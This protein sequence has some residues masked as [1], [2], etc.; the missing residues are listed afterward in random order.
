MTPAYG[1]PPPQEA[2]RLFQEQT[3][4]APVLLPPVP[5]KHGG[6]G[7]RRSVQQT[8][9]TGLY[10]ITH[11]D[12]V[13][14]ILQRGILSHGQIEARGIAYVPIYDPVIVS[15]RKGI[16][17]ANGRSLWDYANAYFQA[18]NPMMY[19]V[20]QE[21]DPHSIAVVGIAPQVLTAGGTMISDGNAAH[22][23]SEILTT[24]GG[25]ERLAR[26]WKAI[27]A[28]W[29]NPFDGSKRV[30]MAECLVPEHISPSYIHTIYVPSHRAAEVLRAKIGSSLPV[31]PEPNMFFRPV[32]R[33]QIT[34]LLTLIEGDMFFSTMQTLTVSVNTVGIMGKGLASRAKDQFPD[35]YVRYQ[36]ACRR[37]TLTLG[38]PY[39][40]KRDFLMDQELADEPASLS[41]SNGKK[42]FLLFATKG[43]WR[44]D[45]SMEGIER[46]LHW[47]LE[48]H[49]EEGIESLAIPALG[50]GLGNLKWRDVGPLM[51]RLLAKLNIPVAIYLP[52][53]RIIPEVETRA[54]FLLGKAGTQ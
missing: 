24:A 22:S 34:P 10:Y 37:E 45:A 36:D 43:H 17:L 4:H 26:N 39:L 46:G 41:T 19:R 12:N 29:W 21:R 3:D 8:E 14:S 40:Y 38:R 32:R 51:C 42:W 9:I 50:C 54:E 44:D 31:V 15:R 49:A 11:V 18:R 16:R 13:P 20:T 7:R 27:D 47:L 35:V 30:I 25:L 28:E 23:E 53:E 33:I 5:A 52:R 48:H 2:M 6:A 1:S